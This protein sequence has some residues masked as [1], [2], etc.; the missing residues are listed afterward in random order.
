MPVVLESTLAPL[1]EENDRPDTIAISDTRKSPVEARLAAV[2]TPVLSMVEM[3][4]CKTLPVVT[5]LLYRVPPV[6]ARFAAVATP[7]ASMV[8]MREC[9]T[10]PVVTLLLYNVPPVDARL[11]AVATP[12]DSIVL[13][14]ELLE[15]ICAPVVAESVVLTLYIFGSPE[16]KVT[17][18]SPAPVIFTTSALY[19]LE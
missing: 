17:V 14:L 10:L 5:L 2:A 4:E 16:V 3:R 6:E 13:N 7:V 8:E 12:V 9:K 15:S 1:A 11:A 18:V 19:I